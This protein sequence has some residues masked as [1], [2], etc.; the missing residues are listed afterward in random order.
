MLIR[1]M[2]RTKPISW[3]L[4]IFGSDIMMTYGLLLYQGSTRFN[5]MRD[6]ITILK[7]VSMDLVSFVF[8]M[9]FFDWL[10]VKFFQ[11]E[12]ENLLDKVLRI[13]GNTMAAYFGWFTIG[14]VLL[15]LFTNF[16]VKQFWLLTLVSGILAIMNWLLRRITPIK[17]QLNP[18]GA[19]D[20]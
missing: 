8:I 9:L 1:D 5:P 14:F 18:M 20:N 13:G 15:Q 10:H 4:F 19:D 3:L 11:N 2:V 12:S 7:F 6:Y 17:F 16:Q